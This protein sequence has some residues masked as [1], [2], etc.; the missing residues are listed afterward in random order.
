MLV[1][2][3]VPITLEG[4]RQVQKLCLLRMADLVKADQFYTFLKQEGK[5]SVKQAKG[6]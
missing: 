4:T 2:S 1:P 5:L 3:S 6:Q